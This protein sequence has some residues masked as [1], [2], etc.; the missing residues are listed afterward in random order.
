MA[1]NTDK[2]NIIKENFNHPNLI[3]IP[4]ATYT[5]NPTL[6]STNNQNPQ[7]KDNSKNNT[8]QL[9]SK[10]LK[11]DLNSNNEVEKEKPKRKQ[12]DKILDE[13]DEDQNFTDF[14]FNMNPFNTSDINDID[15]THKENENSDNDELILEEKEITN[16][17]YGL[18][19]FIS[20]NNNNN[21]NENKINNNEINNNNINIPRVLSG[22]LYNNNDT[23][24]NS[25]F[26]FENLGLNND[27]NNLNRNS[28]NPM[29]NNNPLNNSQNMN[30][31]NFFNVNNNIYTMNENNLQNQIN[32]LNN[33]FTMNGKSGWVCSYCKN[34]NYKS[35]YLI[36]NFFLGRNNC[37]RCGMGNT[38]MFFQESTSLSSNNLPSLE[39]NNLSNSPIKYQENKFNLSSESSPN[40]NKKK[41]KKQF[42]EREGDWI[43][44]KCNNLNFSFRNICNRCHLEKTEN[45]SLTVKGNQSNLGK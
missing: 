1:D 39:H 34:F 43:C 25:I 27:N 16:D 26:N 9:L 38:G 14:N 22:P 40:L 45:N 3:N 23:N 2:N 41:K 10:D 21:N 11:N 7:N 4:N 19:N 17:L 13:N 28:Y 24:I 42:I 32:F 29:N 36:F 8:Q 15:I 37:N 5:P 18:T 44:L 12:T 31:A 30:N 35:K 33:S 20:N 6:S